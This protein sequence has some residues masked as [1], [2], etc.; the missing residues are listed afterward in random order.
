ME[1]QTLQDGR[2]LVTAGDGMAG[3][4]AIWSS[5]SFSSVDVVIAVVF[6]QSLS[7]AFGSAG[8]DAVVNFCVSHGSS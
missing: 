4:G 5:I 1:C 3:F 7:S 6:C 8:S 2:P